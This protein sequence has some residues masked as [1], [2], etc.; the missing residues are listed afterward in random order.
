MELTGWVSAATISAQI[1]KEFAKKEGHR[2]SHR[3]STTSGGRGLTLASSVPDLELDDA[4]LKPAFFGVSAH[5]PVPLDL[6]RPLTIARRL[7]SVVRTLRK[8]GSAN[9]RRG[10]LVEV[11][12]DKSKH[13]RRFPHSRLA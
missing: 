9:G 7:Y 10:V 13:K 3:D 8:E 11:V 2:V 5:F 12:L 1:P 4:V 6:C